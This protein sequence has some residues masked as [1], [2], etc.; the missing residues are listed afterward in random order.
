MSYPISVCIIAKNE[1]KYIE[2]CLEH[3]KP[4]GMEIVV[5]DTGSTDKTKE[6]ARKYTDKVYDFTWVDDFSAARNYCAG[7]A[8]ND[9]ILAIDCDE[10]I[11]KFEVQVIKEY[12]QK[13]SKTAGEICIRNLA[14][15]NDG[16]ESCVDEKIVRFYHRDF[17]EFAYP[18]HESIVPKKHMGG[19]EKCLSVPITVVHHGYH[20]DKDAMRVKQQRN[21]KLLYRM[22]E[23]DDERKAYTLFQIGQSQQILENYKEAITSYTSCLELQKGINKQSMIKCIVQLATTYAQMDEPYK[24]LMVMEQHKE[25]VKSARI[26][27]TYALALLGVGEHLKALMQLVLVTTM[28]DR[29]ELGE[30]LIKCYDYIIKLYHMYGEAGLAEHFVMERDQRRKK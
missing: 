3:L 28:E 13:N 14:Y 2:K 18:V 25:K 24:A 22:L 12:I 7:K 19:Q 5:V 6:I 30:D 11:E 21:L 15:R 1:E 17:F 29:E 26:T 16:E 23:T 4:Y 10:Y 27:Y 9:W 8:T 20:I